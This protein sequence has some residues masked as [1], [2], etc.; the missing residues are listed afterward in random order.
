MSSARTSTKVLLYTSILSFLGNIYSTYSYFL[1]IP[2]QTLNENQMLLPWLQ[3]I[4]S[5]LQ[6]FFIVSARVSISQSLAKHLSYSLYGIMWWLVKNEMEE[7]Q[8]ELV[9]SSFGY[10]M[11]FNWVSSKVNE[12]KTWQFISRM[13]YETITSQIWSSNDN[14]AWDIQLHISVRNGN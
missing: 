10:W 13:R 9:T 12:S 6:T 4:L 14:Y 11:A 8:K 5:I 1:I 3:D 7:I 2:I